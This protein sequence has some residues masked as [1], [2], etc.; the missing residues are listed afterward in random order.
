LYAFADQQTTGPEQVGSAY[1][2]FSE[3]GDKYGHPAL[4]LI[5]RALCNIH[6]NKY[7]EA[8]PLLMEALVKVSPQPNA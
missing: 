3:L 8:E 4:T 7:T 2:I 1:Y 5:G 6:N